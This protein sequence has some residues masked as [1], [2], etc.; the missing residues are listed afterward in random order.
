MAQ[1]LKGGL[2]PHPRTRALS[3]TIMPF[4]EQ[5]W[6]RPDEGIWETRG[7]L[8]HFTH[9]KVLAWVAFDRAAK[10]ALTADPASERAARWRRVANEI[11]EDV[12]R[13]CLRS[14]PR[15]LRAVL[16]L[17]GNWTR[18]CCAIPLVGFLPPEDPRV[19]GTVAA[20]ERH[21]VRD[22]LVLRYDTG[23][24]GGWSAAR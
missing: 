1:A 18:A 16:R 21:L 3:E 22:G 4:L 24:R 14:G 15:Q 17:P 13:R 12:C 11:H 20:I 5:A 8:R 10:M 19:V 6:R 9:S 23:D 2:P 7:G